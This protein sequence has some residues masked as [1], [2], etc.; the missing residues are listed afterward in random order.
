M[1]G[2][3]QSISLTIPPLSVLYFK[4]TPK[5]IKAKKEVKT[6]EIKDIEPLVIPAEVSE[7]AEIIE[8][9]PKVSSKPKAKAEK[10]AEKP[11]SKTSSNKKSAKA[12]SAKKPKEEK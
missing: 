2:Y 12:S 4:G 6:E 8:K 9:K 5:K 7:K 11:K 10:P 3:D 1:H